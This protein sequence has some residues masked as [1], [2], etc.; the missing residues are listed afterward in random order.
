MEQNYS[1]PSIKISGSGS[2]GGG[3]Y[4]EI[5]ISG[6]GKVT[7]DVSCN[8]IKISGSATIEGN[9]KAIDATVSGSARFTQ[10]VSAENLKVSGS[11]RVE[12]NV[13]A[14]RLKTSGSFTVEGSLSA[15][16]ITTSGSLKVANDC[17]SETF[18][19]TGQCRIGGLLNAGEIDISLEGKSEIKSIGAEHI[20]VTLL[21][22]GSFIKDI[23][24]LFT[25]Y[26]GK[27]ICESI[28]GDEIYLE[29]TIC[30]VVRGGRITIGR[31]CQIKLVEYS[32][33]LDVLEDGRVDVKQ[34]L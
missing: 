33:T 13:T 10:E 9:L 27:L 12:S 30:D 17:N 29:N 28:E 32:E 8:L 19:L 24:G 3:E 34:P 15:E 18:N 4:E 22:F 11:A 16:E 23:V 1:K 14:K 31:G 7:G 20:K 21:K 2:A 26:S 25:D 6:S 5:R